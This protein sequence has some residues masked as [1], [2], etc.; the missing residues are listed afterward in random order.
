MQETVT[1]TP[2]LMP[3]YGIRTDTDMAPCTFSVGVLGWGRGIIMHLINNDTCMQ[4]YGCFVYCVTC[5]CK[6]IINDM[7]TLL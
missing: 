1:S 6:T 7:K 5:W 2:V 4:M 3:R